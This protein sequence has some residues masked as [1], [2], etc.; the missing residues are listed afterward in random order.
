MVAAGA[1][2]V[3]IAG[4]RKQRSQSLAAKGAYWIGSMLSGRGSWYFMI[5]GVQWIVAAKR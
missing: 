2:K 5:Y 4:C 1:I 3:K